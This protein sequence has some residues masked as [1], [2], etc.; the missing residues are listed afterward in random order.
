MDQNIPT[1]QNFSPSNTQSQTEIIQSP[2]TPPLPQTQHPAQNVNQQATGFNRLL[3][4]ILIGVGVNIAGSFLMA[5]AGFLFSIFL[6]PVMIVGLAFIFIPGSYMFW[7]GFI[8]WPVYFW[9][10]P[11]SKSLETIFKTFVIYQV[12]GL[13]YLAVFWIVVMF[14]TMLLTQAFSVDYDN[15]QGSLF[16]LSTFGFFGVFYASIKVRDRLFADPKQDW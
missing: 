2:Q 16:K 8:N 14:G 5:V 3:Q 11:N 6:G 12:L 13:L 4:A 15:V 10:Y 9:F 1:E 7:T